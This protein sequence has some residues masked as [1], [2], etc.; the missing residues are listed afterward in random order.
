MA[1]RL[2]QISKPALRRPRGLRLE[3]ATERGTLLVSFPIP[4]ADFEG[5]LTETETQIAQGILAGL[6]H[7]DIARRR[8]TAPRTI[9]N[10]VASIYKKLGVGSRLE[11]SVIA[12][13]RR[14]R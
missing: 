8:G 1:K 12:V 10:Q 4:N 13:A 2:S 6:S 3:E 9:A 7:A 11:L 5:A 14:Q